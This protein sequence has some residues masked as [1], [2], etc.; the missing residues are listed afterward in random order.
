MFIDEARQILQ[1]REESL[2]PLLEAWEALRLRFLTR[3]AGRVEM[4][5]ARRARREAQADPGL[6][7]QVQDA[8][9]SSLDDTGLDQRLQALYHELAG[10]SGSPA[11]RERRD[12]L[13][14]DLELRWLEPRMVAGRAWTVRDLER[15]LDESRLD[16]ERR[17]VWEALTLAGRAGAAEALAGLALA[18][19][20]AREAGFASLPD[21]CGQRL[22]L[23]P[24][25][26]EGWLESLRGALRPLIREEA[27]RDLSETA[28]ARRRPIAGLDACALGALYGSGLDGRHGLPG[29]QHTAAH[30]GRDPLDLLRDTADLLGLDVDGPLARWTTGGLV[31]PT[32][33]QGLIDGPEGRWPVVVVDLQAGW[34]GCR[35]ALDV[36]GQVLGSQAQA[37]TARESGAG[38]GV[39]FPLRHVQSLTMGRLLSDLPAT[40]DW[41]GRLLEVADLPSWEAWW[42]RR[43]LLRLGQDLLRLEWLSR[44]PGLNVE[45][46]G[47]L[48]LELRRDWLALPPHARDRDLWAADPLLALR[49]EEVLPRLGAE[50]L[51][52]SLRTRWGLAGLPLATPELG[53]R[54]L[55]HLTEPAE[56]EDWGE[57]LDALREGLH[58]RDL[59]DAWRSRQPA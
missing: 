14:T 25:E 53:G 42:R 31:L 49:P 18:E 22:L 28:E 15:A 55:D 54:L 40:G 20:I 51:A 52:A 17:P 7:E 43:R 32:Q 46:A 44:A 41:A 2:R 33:L 36:L 57:A 9:L 58:P 45:D 50:L 16:E 27:E 26:S 23:D 10:L 39:A 30:A 13:L 6:F 56:A 4:L 48:W 3:R 34:R 5:E 47:E 21:A 24:G 37:V 8:V 12:Q 1:A 59:V 35:D 38:A 29:S 11:L 19:E